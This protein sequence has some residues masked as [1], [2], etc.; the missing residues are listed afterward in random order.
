MVVSLLADRLAHRR[1]LAV[2]ALYF[3]HALEL[4]L[5]FHSGTHSGRSLKIMI[6]S[7]NGM[8]AFYLSLFREN[9]AA[10]LSLAGDPAGVARG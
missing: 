1:R 2:M 4:P 6:E 10:L 5:S 8:F 7:S 9:L 3:E